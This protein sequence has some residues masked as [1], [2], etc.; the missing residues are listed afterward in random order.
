[1][2]RKRYI[3]SDVQRKY[4]ERAD[5][6]SLELIDIL[7]NITP[8]SRVSGTARDLPWS[9]ATCAGVSIPER[10]DL[11]CHNKLAQAIATVTRLLI[12]LETSGLEHAY[13]FPALGDKFEDSW[14]V[15]C[16][17]TDASLPTV[18]LCYWPAILARRKG[19]DDLMRVMVP[20]R[21]SL[22]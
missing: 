2:A 11:S 21:V 9:V 18:C 16:G 22:M 15:P 20:A 6:L 12:V 7:Q 1:M 17:A 14:M 4:L 10:K 13:R 19:T 8:R 5:R 3:E